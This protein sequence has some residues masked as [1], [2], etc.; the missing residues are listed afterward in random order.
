[1]YEMEGNMKECNFTNKAEAGMEPQKNI[2]HGLATADH[3]I[4]QTIHDES[5]CTMRKYVTFVNKRRELY[6]EVIGDITPW[7]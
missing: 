5:V 1:M 6:D 3:D 4:M 7:I 2:G